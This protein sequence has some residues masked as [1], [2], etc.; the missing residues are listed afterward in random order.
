MNRP[1]DFVHKPPG[2]FSE[3]KTCSP[4]ECCDR[5][6]NVYRFL[7]MYLYPPQV[8]KHIQDVCKAK[9]KDKYSRPP[10][11]P[12]TNTIRQLLDVCFH[13]SFLTE[14]GRRPGFR[15]AY[16]DKSSANQLENEF[17]TMS[18]LVRLRKSRPFTVAEIN[19][20]APAAE[21]TRFLFCVSEKQGHRRELE[22]W[23]LLD[24]GENWS[25]FIRHETSTGYAPPNQLTITSAAPGEISVSAHGDIISG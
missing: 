13:A 3:F 2:L 6:A 11:L 18:R 22:V 14:E 9:K 7:P 15:V 23:A 16:F 5:K 4:K 25:R 10:A 12:A 1:D 17:A 21:L 19:R 24:V 20:L 8:V